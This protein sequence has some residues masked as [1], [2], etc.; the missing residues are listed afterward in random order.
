MC[1]A[2]GSKFVLVRQPVAQSVAHAR[3]L[4]SAR[5]VPPRG[6][7]GHVPPGKFWILDLLRSFLVQS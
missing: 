2:V 1:R 4:H 6:V 5:S 3:S 7:W